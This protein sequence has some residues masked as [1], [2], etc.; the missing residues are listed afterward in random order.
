MRKEEERAGGGRDFIIG[1]KG[2][3]GVK[4]RE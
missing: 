3:S 4:V 1:E 2:E